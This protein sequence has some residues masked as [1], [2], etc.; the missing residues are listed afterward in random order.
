[1]SQLTEAAYYFYSY[2]SK[3]AERMQRLVDA[4][5]DHDLDV[6]VDV[7]T[8]KNQERWVHALEQQIE[9][10]AGVIVQMSLAARQ[11]EWVE[12]ETLYA[13][14][15]GIPV[16]IVRFD[17]VPLP[18]HLVNRQFTPFEDDFAQ[19]VAKLA[20][21][22]RHYR[23]AV[24]PISPAA[25]PDEDNFFDYLAQMSQGDALAR[26]AQ[27]F[28]RWACVHCED[29]TF[30]GRYTPAFH[31]RAAGQP[32]F[33]VVAYLRNP[34][35]VFNAE[36]FS[37]AQLQAALPTLRL[38]TERVNPSVALRDVAQAAAADRVEAALM[39]ALR[40]NAQDASDASSAR[41]ASDAAM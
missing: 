35:L 9:G 16:F 26:L 34:A 30:S 24:D 31:A 6:R 20:H 12:R 4:L 3:D 41:S 21:S 32:L 13:L 38:D 36:R 2:A 18:L 29:V 8:L 7:Q 11:S 17:R 27:R 22:I 14:E 33:S 39:A 25:A 15:R 40:G 23:A 1:M 10:A 37:P 19:G 5:R 28:Y